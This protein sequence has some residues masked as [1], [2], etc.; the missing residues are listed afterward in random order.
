M[1]TNFEYGTKVKV[2]TP[3]G[4]VEGEV[5][6]LHTNNE[7]KQFGVKFNY[8]S[9]GFKSIICAFSKKTGNPYLSQSAKAKGYKVVG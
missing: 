6:W 2:S 5:V 9:S 1:I 3:D 4:I 8:P 7:I